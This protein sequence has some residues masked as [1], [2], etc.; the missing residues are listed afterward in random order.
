MN[1]NQI[2]SET[3]KEYFIQILNYLVM[4]IG[5]LCFM[6]TALVAALLSIPK[7]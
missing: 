6:A 7:V 2:I 1:H 4:R 5:W 3:N